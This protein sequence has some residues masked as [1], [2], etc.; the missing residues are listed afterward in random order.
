M[1]RG[2]RSAVRGP[3][4]R[5]AGRCQGN[6]HRERALVVAVAMAP[7]QFAVE[8]GR[9]GPTSELPGS[10]VE[11]GGDGSGAAA[12]AT[13]KRGSWCRLPWH[14]GIR[15]GHCPGTAAGTAAIHRNTE[16]PPQSKTIGCSPR[17]ASWPMGRCQGD[18]HR[19]RPLV[20]AINMAP[21]ESHNPCASAQSF[22]CSSTTSAERPNSVISYATAIGR[23][24]RT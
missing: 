24:L 9:T 23:S 22:S 3:G 2:Q 16:V 7:A 20:V 5:A 11:R 12:I 19:K 4:C 18:H 13:R 21:D 10:R 8:F 14:V 15:A 6:H 17:R 1:D